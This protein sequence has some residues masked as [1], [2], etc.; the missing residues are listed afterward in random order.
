MFRDPIDLCE[1]RG[2]VFTDQANQMWVVLR[3]CNPPYVCSDSAV[4]VGGER[5]GEM[6]HLSRIAAPVYVLDKPPEPAD[7]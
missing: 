4:A 6:R 1:Q 7:I 2:V 3:D 5:S